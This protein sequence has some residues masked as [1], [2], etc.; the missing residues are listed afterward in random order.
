MT[1]NQNEQET[2]TKL[3][4]VLQD[5]AQASRFENSVAALIGRLLGLT[6]AVAKSGFQHG[7]DAGSSGRQGR[8]LRIECKKYADN[9]ALSDRELLGEVDQAV[10][11]D[12]ALEVW[13]LAATR[14]VSEQLEQS[15]DQKGLSI[16]VPIVIV[17]WKPTGLS[18]LGALCASAPDIVEEVFST[19][20]GAL[21]KA[22]HSIAGD[23]VDQLQRDLAAWSLGFETLRTLSQDQLTKI[24][25][26]PRTS[27][28]ALGQNAAGGA[29][30]KTV[31]RRAVC[32]EFDSWWSGPAAGDAPAVALGPDGVGKTWATL[33]WLVGRS[34]DQ[35]IVLVIPSSA[36]AGIT[37]ASET[38]VKQFL[39]HRL[40]ELSGGVRDPSHWLRRLDH[41]LKRPSDEGPV[42]TV[43]FDGINQEPSVP[44]LALLKMLQGDAFAGRVR[45]IVGTRNLY[46]DDRLGRLRGLIIP[47][48][49]IP[50]TVFELDAGGELDQMLGFEGLTRA[51][52]HPDL[53][54]LARTPRL[55]NLVIRLKDR[56]VDTGAVTI[57]RLLWEYGR[58]ALGE[59]AGR[60]F[61]EDEWRAWL[62][63]IANR[64]RD[65]VRDFSVKALGET[66]SRPDLTENQVFARLSDIID[67]QFTTPGPAGSHQFKPAVVSHALGAALLAQLDRLD[68][69]TFETVENE[70]S[71]WL[72]PI[73]GLDQRAEI[74]RAAVS[75][76]VEQDVATNDPVAGPLVTAWLQTQNVPDSHRMELAGLAA[77]LPDALLDAVEH[78]VD[79]TQA[80]A[81]LWAVN[82]LRAIPREVGDPLNRILARARRWLGV[83]SRDIHM[84]SRRSEDQENHRAKLFLDRVGIDASGP[85][86]VLGIG[87]T[88][89]DRDDG[90]LAQTV[91]SILEGFP[92][93]TATPTFEV[94]AI[95]L[96]VSGHCPAWAGLKWLCLLNEVD[97]EP[98]T[99]ALRALSATMKL[100]VAEPTVN[101]ALS[102]RAAAL[103]LWLSGEEFDEVA[104]AAL[105]PGLDRIMS[106]E[107]D[108]LPNPGRSFFAL[109]RRHA[110][111]VLQDKSIAPLWRVDRTSELWLDPSFEPL[112]EFI[113]EVR[114]AANSIDVSMLDRHNGTTIEDHNF[115]KLE[116]A[117]AR[118][119]PDLLADSMAQK[120]RQSRSLPTQARYWRAISSTEQL[121]LTGQAE[122][123][124]ARTLRLSAREAENGSELLAATQLLILELHAACANQQMET[125]LDADL[126]HILLDLTHI[127]RTPTQSKAEALVDRFGE[128]SVAQRRNLIVL[129][130][131]ASVRPSER[132]WEW[133]LAV[134][135]RDDPDLAG[136]AFRCLSAFDEVRFGS[137]LLARDW[138]WSPLGDYWVNHYGSGAVIRAAGATPFDQL[139]PRIA[140]W[141]LLEA[142]RERGGDPS[143]VRLA[144][145]IFGGVLTAEQ[146]ELPDPGALVTIDRTVEGAGPD[147]LLLTPGVPPGDTADPL[148]NLRRDIDTEAQLEARRRAVDTALTRIR[149]AR[150]AGA[151][152]YLANVEVEDMEQVVHHAPDQVEIWLQGAADR[153]KD[154]QRRVILAEPA[155][156]A[157]CEALLRHG[158]SCRADLWRNL[159]ATTSTRFIGK[160]SVDEMIHMVFR[161]PDS[162][163]VAALHEDLV[164]LKNSSSD[165]DLFN[166]AL[167]ANLNGKTQWLVETIAKDKA[168]T[169]P[170]R[171]KRGV[172]LEG[173]TAGNSLPQSAAWPDGKIDTA[174]EGL[175]WRS[176]RF[177]YFEGCAHHWWRA[178][179][180]A[181]DSA[182]AYASWILFLR[183][184]DRR[185]WV[186]ME[187]DVREDYDAD[188]FSKLK[189]SH[190][191]INL[192]H[193][194]RQME[195]REEKLDKE[196]LGRETRSGVGPWG[197]VSD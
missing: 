63:E 66:A 188:A 147:L 113:A 163:A 51:D 26:L 193:V 103:L 121:I 167:G 12:P 116:L 57:H 33:A 17:D 129:L 82:A 138:S 67:G 44:W 53:L 158:Q 65:G 93:A 35:P 20:A 46:F 107:A 2:L 106:Y 72:D 7:A 48:V 54:E 141:R 8:R 146:I 73:A 161:V 37:T 153:T 110:D 132:L 64:Y 171:R 140:P 56:L 34:T 77:K 43:F 133:V 162:P 83:V 87:L 84:G 154:F 104:A 139:A 18:A 185:A 75:I 126:E 78:S 186:W 166:L 165:K 131:N 156:L 127:L 76:L 130:W 80:S 10:A 159:K 170:W 32:R 39:A 179:L 25:T 55:L 105:D 70:I 96:A 168:S 182:T 5:E 16:G 24:W 175:R 148:S 38:A 59:R 178:Y 101:A 143:E 151:S 68:Q 109:E 29:Q 180:A 114:A 92:M 117:L 58:D 14:D 21:A 190:A 6:I 172:V 137:H 36:A 9:T 22:L 189:M 88:F 155:Y 197:K 181:P 86:R 112:T 91:P 23:A 45:V 108:Y 3:K 71:P 144:A 196:F 145:S 176:A 122:S 40:Y 174:H 30:V 194:K 4:S 27:T 135:D 120:L 157:L 49:P 100:R 142:A 42:M 62:K 31:V 97:P 177:R 50:V 187:Q 191:E 79:Q 134:A 47:A 89:V 74:L 41:L 94:A 128:G 115:E 124:A 69:P 13:I 173:F 60:S 1:L 52:L 149:A 125:V 183:S 98:T 111:Q 11:R 136:L 184:V 119:A 28:A 169:L 81:R 99:A 150:A 195:K 192:A 118:C 19:E 15:L 90:A 123:E 152:L 85:H 95:A 61:S 160:A 164:G 102:A